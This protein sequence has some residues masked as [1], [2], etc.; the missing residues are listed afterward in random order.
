MLSKKSTSKIAR[1]AE[2]KRL[3]NRSTKSSVKTLIAKAEK[4][5]E[6]KTVRLM[7][8]GEADDVFAEIDKEI[9][10]YEPPEIESF[11]EFPK[12]EEVV[13]EEE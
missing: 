1:V 9:D 10:E 8:S 5:I 4:K 2:K 6:K 3:R 12:E 11:P 13:E 7:L